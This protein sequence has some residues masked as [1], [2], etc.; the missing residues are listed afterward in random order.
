MSPP[1]WDASFM[2]ILINLNVNDLEITPQN[3][4][5]PHIK[6]YAPQYMPSSCNERKY[7]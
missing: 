4:I 2:I 5:Q 1:P 3:L 7:K 6:T